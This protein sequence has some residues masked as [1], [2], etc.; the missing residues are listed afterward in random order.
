MAQKKLSALSKEPGKR[1]NDPQLTDV[2]PITRDPDGVPGSFALLIG[3]I[4]NRSNHNGS[5]PAS[6]ISDFASASQALINT[7]INNLVNAAPGTLDTLSELATA[8]GND[9]NFAASIAASLANKVQIGGSIGGSPASPYVTHEARIIVAPYGDGRPA[10]FKCANNTDNAV[11]INQAI[12][13]AVTYHAMSGRACQ[14]FMLDGDYNIGTRVIPQNYVWLR[15][16][17]MFATRL[18]ATSALTAGMIDNKAEVNTANP[19][20]GGILSDFE[21][22]GAGMNPAREI[23]GVNSDNL[24]SCK[25]MR[26]YVHDTNATGIGPDDFYGSTITECIVLNCGYMN[27]KTITGASWTTNT[28]TF[29]T[30]AAHGY[31]AGS[32]VIVVTGMTPAAYNG[33]YTVASTP[34]ST[35]FTVTSTFLDLNPGT[36]TGFGLASDSLIGHNG[37]GIASG[38]NTHEATIITNNICIGNQNNNFLIEADTTGTD[39]QAS[40]IYSNNISIQAGQVGFLNTGTPNVQF[41]NNFD[42]GSVYGSQIAGVTQVRT[43]SAAVWASSVATY[44]TA[45]AHSLAVGQKVDINGMTATGYNGYYTVASV[46]DSTHFTIAMTSN[47]GT[48]TVFGTATSIAHSTDDTLIEN[49]IFTDN[50]LYGIRAVSSA[51]RYKISGN[52]VKRSWNYG[53]SVNASSGNITDNFV[54]QNGR[55]GIDIETGSGT[56]KPLTKLTVTGNHVYNNGQRATYDGIEVQSANTTCP[57]T[58]LLITNNQIYDDQGTKTQRYGVILRTG[59]ILADVTVVNNNLQGNATGGILVQNTA[60][61][62]SVWNNTGVNPEYKQEMG[63]LSAGTKSFNRQVATYFTATLGANITAS[64]PNGLIKKDRLTIVL[65]Q[66]GTGGRVVTWPGNAVLSGGSLVVAPAAGAVTIVQFVWDGSNWNEI[67]RTTSSVQLSESQ[68]TNLVTD[69]VAKAP[70]ASPTLTGTP[71][72]PTATPGTNTTQIATTSFVVAALTTAIASKQ[73]VSEKGQSNGYASL[74]GGGKI[75]V[76]QLPNSIMEYQGTWNASTNTPTLVDGSGNT[77]DVYRVT[78]AATR[79]LGSGSITFDVGDYAVYNSSGVWEKSDTTDAVASFNSRTGNITPASG[80]YTASQVTNTPAGNVAATTAQAAINEL[81]GEKVAK[82]G[83]TMTGP[84]AFQSGS[85]TSAVSVNTLTANRIAMLPDNSGTIL[86]GSATQT[87]TNKTID[88]SNNTI[89]NIASNSRLI[90]QTAHGFI[91]GDAIYYTGSAWA[92]GTAA[93]PLLG[94]VSSVVDANNFI[95]TTDGF[96]TVAGAGWTPGATYYAHQTTA[97]LLTATE[98]TIVGQFRQPVL[99]AISATT[100]QLL[101]SLSGVAAG[102]SPFSYKRKT[103]T[104][105]R[106]YTGVAN[107]VSLTTTAISASTI[108]LHPFIVE[109]ATTFDAIAANV[110]N[111]V[112]STNIRL[113]IYTD[114]GNCYPNA[115]VSG[116]DSGNLSSATAG[117]K[118]FQFASSITLQPGLYWL[119]INSDGG[120]TV[121]A[122]PQNGALPILGYDNTLSTIAGSGYTVSSTFGAFPS[123]LPA[124]G[125]IVQPVIPAVFL[126]AI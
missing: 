61:T 28:I 73:D 53:I 30:G 39:A 110:T 84:L 6:S 87:V 11:E 120:P 46:P 75:P 2:V 119:A 104:F 22:D 74:D 124:G 7:A 107:N 40:Y 4:L 56:Y 85:F 38:A 99:V 1:V 106:W 5:Q 82:A 66:D 12:S 98:P 36:A 51:D 3:S 96:V 101:I 89:T 97:G 25:I 68:V 70:I 55:D 24:N 77:G 54:Y 125:T 94:M 20:I 17:G 118:S 80:D 41:T 26:L 47:P 72:A 81:D 78:V 69:L 45:T 14:V 67:S 65:T 13:Q 117:V 126:R 76:G 114:D 37:I 63:T 10:D 50:V 42:Y 115:L 35:T 57:V 92:K 52:T 109:R 33:R 112:L 102:P 103:A 86:I 111:L 91:V 62:I 43:I 93:N 83:D 79:N 58:D 32:S 27:K 95:L 64:L 121:R 48:A 31:T 59:G 123:T 29:T 122:I 19:W 15:G 105:D 100:A 49:N 8:L 90:T 88:G 34:N 108:R 71:A 60:D 21:L 18:H 9:P 23:K 113:A 44:T 116:S 16:A